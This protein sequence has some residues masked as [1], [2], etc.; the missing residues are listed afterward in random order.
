[1]TTN[2]QNA[3]TVTVTGAGGQI[4]YSLLFRIAKGEV[5]GDRVVNLRL[6]E[7]EQGVQAAR[8]VALE[9]ADCAFPLLGEVSIT[10]ELS[11]GFK[12]ANAVFLVG[13]KPRQK[14]EE[15]ADLLTANG[16]IFG[17][18]GKAIAE[19]AADDVRVIVV[20]NPA[21]TNAAIVAAHAEGL[22]PRRVTA[23]TR[24]DHNR[25]LAQ[26]ADKLGVAVR[27]L[28]NMTVWGNH[29]ASQFPDVAELT[30]NGEKVADKLD[31]AW[32]NDEFIPR[33]AKRGA[34]IIEVRGRSSAASAASAALDHMR[35]W[36]NGT[37]EGDW[38][39]VALPSDGSYGIPEGLVFSF[40]CRS[41][42]GEWEIVQGL[43]ISPA[44][45]ERIDANIKE[46]QEEKAAVEEAG[47][48]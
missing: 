21:N 29:S 28:K 15:R 16:K 45:Q 48:L 32:V 41:V 11:E 13:A 44:Q 19:H 35:D 27:D 17:P 46:L 6:L 34:E 25:G 38:V 4:G 33:V 3:V 2:N 42:D 39:S 43:E 36:V 5:F 47:L 24:L 8:G 30:L 31:A 7:T 18:Q 26:V 10:T 20:G 23:L 12:D 1:M 14:G 40:P 37:A 9:L 22:D